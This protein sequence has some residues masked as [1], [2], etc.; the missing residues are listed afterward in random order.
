MSKMNKIKQRCLYPN[1]GLDFKATLKVPFIK[2]WIYVDKRD[3]KIKVEEAAKEYGFEFVTDDTYT[4][5]VLF[6][7]GDITLYFVYNTILPASNNTRLKNLLYNTGYIFSQNVPNFNISEVTP[8]IHTLFIDNPLLPE[9]VK[10]F[11][12]GDYNQA[13]S[14]KGQWT[15]M[16]FNTLLGADGNDSNSNI[17]RY[18]RS[19]RSKSRRSLKKKNKSRKRSPKRK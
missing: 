2:E 14:S 4:S 19:R 11:P 7:K 9:G 15:D 1:S 10:M 16:V 18:T 13:E 12:V 8:K 17:K 3:D 6:T 5:T